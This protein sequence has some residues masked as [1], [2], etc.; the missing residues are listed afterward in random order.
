MFISACGIRHNSERYCLRCSDRR[1]LLDSERP[2]PDLSYIV[3]KYLSL[4]IKDEEEIL[5]KGKKA[6]S[7]EELSTEKQAEASARM[8]CHIKPFPMC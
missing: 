8:T 7:W 6:L 2:S 1:F 4:S 3:S 5:G